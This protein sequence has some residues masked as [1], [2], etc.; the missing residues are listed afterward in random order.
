M[1]SRHI[2]ILAILAAIAIMGLVTI[3][4]QLV[5]APRGCGS[6][7]QFK[8]LTHEFEKE[9]IDAASTGDSNT[10]S[11]LLEQYNQDVRALDFS[12]P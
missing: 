6:C 3:S 11:G 8:K 5:S 4:V 1:K 10:I 9:V 12:I 2:P 7:V